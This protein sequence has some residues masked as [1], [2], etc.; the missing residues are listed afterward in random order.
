M[1]QYYGN[2]DS[3]KEICNIKLEPAI[4]VRTL[5][6]RDAETVCQNL[7]EGLVIEW[8]DEDVEPEEQTPA[9]KSEVNLYQYQSRPRREEQESDRENPIECLETE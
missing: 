3:F 1:N 7:I 2:L 4:K 8:N 9:S 6:F 5:S